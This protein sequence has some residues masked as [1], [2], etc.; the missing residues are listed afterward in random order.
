MHPAIR[1]ASLP[2]LGGDGAADEDTPPSGGPAVLDRAR[3]AAR[4]TGGAVLD[5]IGDRAARSTA[6]EVAALRAE[7]ARTRSELEAEIALLRAELDA[8]GPAGPDR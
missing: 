2:A 1:L 4:R 7:L 6:A 5:R 3:R 8:A